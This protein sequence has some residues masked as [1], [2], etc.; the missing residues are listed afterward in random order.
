MGGLR[1][2]EVE[3]DFTKNFRADSPIVEAYEMV[4][5]IAVKEGF[6]IHLF[7]PETPISVACREMVELADKFKI[8]K[9]KVKKTT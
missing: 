3:T 9:S 6:D 2:L 5:K 1:W 4:R 8:Q 7:G